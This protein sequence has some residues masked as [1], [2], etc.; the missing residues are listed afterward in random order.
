MA[1]VASPSPPR[2]S[3]FTHQERFTLRQLGALVSS[4]DYYRRRCADLEQRLAVCP[5]G[6]LR[7]RLIRDLFAARQ[8]EQA[9]TLNLRDGVAHLTGLVVS[10]YAEAG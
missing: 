9:A 8:G 3:A 10:V 2:H 1:T 5:E 7:H 4:L 6:P